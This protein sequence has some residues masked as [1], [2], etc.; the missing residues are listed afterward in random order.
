MENLNTDKI[1]KKI[2]NK[3]KLEINNHDFNKLVMNKIIS[4]THRQRISYN[5]IMYLMVFILTDLG[6]LFILKLFN[7]SILKNSSSSV[8]ILD[9]LFTPLMSIKSIIIENSIV[10]Y[11]GIFILVFFLL[12]RITTYNFRY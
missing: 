10:Q 7:I 2:L 4:K 5:S 9:T 3:S 11:S 12:N 6:I 1:T 8:S